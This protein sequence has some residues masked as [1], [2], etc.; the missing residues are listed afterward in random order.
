MMENVGGFTRYDVEWWHY[1][2]GPLTGLPLLDF[3]M[4]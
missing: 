2:Y 1:T 4:K 3:Q